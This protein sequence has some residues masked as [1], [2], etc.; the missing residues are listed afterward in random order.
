[1]VNVII[2]DH[3]SCVDLFV[4][5]LSIQSLLFRCNN[6]YWSKYRRTIRDNNQSIIDIKYRM[7][8]TELQMENECFVLTEIIRKNLIYSIN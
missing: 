7:N 2:Y 8:P 4:L 3:H 1:M 5:A 6:D